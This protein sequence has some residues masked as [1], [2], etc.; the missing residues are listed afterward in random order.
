MAA[1][2]W[3]E[4]NNPDHAPSGCLTEMLGDFVVKNAMQFEAWCTLFFEKTTTWRVCL[5]I[6]IKSFVGILRIEKLPQGDVEAG[7]SC[8]QVMCFEQNADEND[9][10][11]KNLAGARVSEK[12]RL[13]DI[14]T[15]GAMA[16][17]S[18]DIVNEN[19]SH[20]N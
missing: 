10:I 20:L 12:Q 19:W 18:G 4:R 13:V 14:L 16:L 2:D 7:V 15:R 3:L 9:C 5:K 17:R 11:R 1:D 6:A 8:E